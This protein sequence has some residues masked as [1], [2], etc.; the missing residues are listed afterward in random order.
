MSRAQREVRTLTG[1]KGLL[2]LE[3]GNGVR[4]LS[5]ANVSPASLY[6]SPPLPLRLHKLRPRHPTGPVRPF[7]KAGAVLIRSKKQ[8]RSA[9]VSSLKL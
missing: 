6:R 1:P 5:S 7:S 8:V 3:G 9:A 2:C 4:T